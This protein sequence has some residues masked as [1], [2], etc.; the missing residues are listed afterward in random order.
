MAMK[1][2]NLLFNILD[3]MVDEVEEANVFPSG[4]QQCI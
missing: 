2:S 4:N 1:D 3:C